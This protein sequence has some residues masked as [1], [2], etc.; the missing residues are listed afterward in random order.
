MQDCC[1]LENIVTYNWITILYSM[2]QGDKFCFKK[3]AYITGAPP[4]KV[5]KI[6]RIFT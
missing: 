2:E 5:P 4:Y 6:L 1:K 3:D